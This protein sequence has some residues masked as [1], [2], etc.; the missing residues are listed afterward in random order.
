MTLTFLQSPPGQ[1]PVVVENIFKASAQRLFEAW[2][3][4]DDVVKWFGPATRNLHHV[5]LDLQVGGGWR[6]S[7]SSNGEHSD[8]I[9]GEYLVIDAPNVLAFTWSHIREFEDGRREATAPSKVTVTFEDV[10]S[11]ARMR[12]VHSQVVLESGRLGISGGWQ[13]GFER[14]AS[15]FD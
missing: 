13:I 1:D 12:L 2:T 15:L 4:P 5:E 14:L 6:F 9:E 8:Y 7:Y 10:A 11:G 3:T